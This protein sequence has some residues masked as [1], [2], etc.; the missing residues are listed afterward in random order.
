F[1]KKREQFTVEERAK[2]LH[3]T[4]TAQRRFLA[5]QRVAAIRSLDE[6]KIKKMNEEAKDPKQKRL[7]NRVVEEIPKKEDT[8]KVPV[9]QDVTE[10]GTK[11]RKGGHIKMIARK[12]PRRQ[13]NVDSDDKHRK[14][15]RVVALDS[16]IDRYHH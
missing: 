2:F 16:T 15:L 1:K 11:K 5:E 13:L 9:K 6:R 12:K 7:K 4:I 8:T 3:D 10:K 14:C